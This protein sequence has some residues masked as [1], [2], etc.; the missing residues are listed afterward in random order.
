[1]FCIIQARMN[2]K[3]LPRKVL[4]KIN[5]KPLIQHVIDRVKKAKLVKKIIVATSNNYTDRVLVNYLKKNKLNYFCG[6]LKNVA[7]RFEEI[8][9]A[10][11]IKSFVR[12]SADSPLID[13]QLIDLSIKKFLKEKYDIVTNVHPRTFPLGQSVEVLCSKIYLKNFKKFNK[14]DRFKEHPP[15]F[16]YENPKKFK[17]YNIKNRKNYSKYR[18]C[19]DTK[20]DF[21]FI[22]KIILKKLNQKNWKYI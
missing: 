2:S 6:S 3:R 8:I 11:N 20:E 13:P 4:T 17:I 14:I 12:I 1:M 5:G 22:K 15:L 7:Q 19:V 21:N 10:Y 9:E 16:F 18:L